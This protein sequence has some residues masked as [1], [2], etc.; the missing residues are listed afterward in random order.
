M[1]RNH[2]GGVAQSV[3]ALP[4]HGRGRGFE[5]RRSRIAPGSRLRISHIFA[6][7]RP[8]RLPTFWRR[9][10]TYRSTERDAGDWA[11]SEINLGYALQTL[12]ELGEVEP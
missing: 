3:R 5:S 2:A 9:A 7:L 1:S 11:Y 10:L 4:C 8:A 12:A 6:P